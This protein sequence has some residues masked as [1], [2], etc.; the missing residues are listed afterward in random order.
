[1]KKYIVMI[2]LLLGTL[3]TLIV[4]NN[5]IKNNIDNNKEIL[6]LNYKDSEALKD[7]K[8]E[9]ENSIEAQKIKISEL[10]SEIKSLND[11]LESDKNKLEEL[12]N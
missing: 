7:K 3:S 4:I 2:I 6:N 12:D 1:M 8:K 5:K 11:T 9:L 10:E